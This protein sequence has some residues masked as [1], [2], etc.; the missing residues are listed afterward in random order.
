M[1]TYREVS[2]LE[3][4]KNSPLDFAIIGNLTERKQI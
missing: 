2:I 4:L 3:I 1:I